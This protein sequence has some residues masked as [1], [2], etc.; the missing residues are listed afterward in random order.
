L[1]HLLFCTISNIRV[2]NLDIKQL[3]LRLER[4]QVARIILIPSL[5]LRYLLKYSISL[6]CKCFLWFCGFLHI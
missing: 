6:P 3:L 5:G 4:W 2:G 1:R